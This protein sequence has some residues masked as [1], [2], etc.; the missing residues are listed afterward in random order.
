MHTKT[1]INRAASCLAVKLGA[2]HAVRLKD[3]DQQNASRM[4]ASWRLEGGSVDGWSVTL[5]CV[6]TLSDLRA[7]WAASVAIADVGESKLKHVPLGDGG[8]DGK[9]ACMKARAAFYDWAKSVGHV[10]VL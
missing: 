7:I 2:Q 9:V 1:N 8:T 3:R 5:E 6:K 4:A 10:S